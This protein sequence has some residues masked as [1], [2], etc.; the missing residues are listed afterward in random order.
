MIDIFISPEFADRVEKELLEN[1]AISTLH[2]ESII[3]EVELTIVVDADERLQELNRQFRGIDAPTDV[4]SFPA[5]EF[6]PDTGLHYLGD[7]MISYPTA[8]RQ[9]DEA[10]APVLDEL[11][12]LVIHGILHLLGH[13]H[14]E[15]D[16]KERMWLAQ[17]EILGKLGINQF[18]L[19]E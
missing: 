16:D 7:M 9:A 13:D 5:D 1:A 6:D 19:P 3:E 17:T 11:Q 14:S 12:L 15:K 8:E 10:G 4:L 2:H 18:D